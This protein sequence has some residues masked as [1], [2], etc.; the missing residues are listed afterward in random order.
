MKLTHISKFVGA[1]TM[2]NP[3]WMASNP[4][5]RLS[6]QQMLMDTMFNMEASISIPGV[7]REMGITLQ[8]DQLMKVGAAVALLYRKKHNGCEP[9]KRAS[10]Y[11]DDRRVNA[12]TE[13][14]R[15]LIVA[16]LRPFIPR[17]EN[18]ASE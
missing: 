11:G 6:I 17:M 1:M 8:H 3:A 18:C 15:D 13:A 7:A 2:L 12:Y 16:A 10:L 4:D 14:D 9:P 5:L